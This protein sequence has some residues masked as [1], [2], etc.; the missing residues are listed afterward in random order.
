MAKPNRPWTV[1]PHTPLQKLDD[2]LWAVESLVPGMKVKRRMTIVRL[3]DGSLVFYHAVPLDEPTLAQVLSFGKPK[4]L[5]VG[6]A[7]H[8]VDAHA[9]AQKLGIGIYGPAKNLPALK[10][11]WPDLGGTL[12]DLP[13][14]PSCVFE[15]LDGTKTG[16]PVQIVRSG[17]RV[18]LV[19][20]DAFS[21]TSDAET[22]FLFRLMGFGGGPRVIK[23]FTL[24]FVNDKPAF[25]AH[26][27]RLAKTK[28]LVRLV[29]CHGAVVDQDAAG[30]LT[31]SAA[32]V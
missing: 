23:P 13:K 32:G 1:T 7:N 21:A 26:L 20:C 5:V 8:G 14:D 22:P 12:E 31:K 10:K 15:Q 30:V 2:N 18:S 11:R 3:T 6:Y 28:G 27:D 25:K 24:F 19:W 17:D 9:F 29:P 4:A 16:E